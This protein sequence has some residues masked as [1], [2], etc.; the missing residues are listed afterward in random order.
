[1]EA[2]GT[3]VR[4]NGNLRIHAAS[5]ECLCLHPSPSHVHCL[6]AADC[7]GGYCVKKPRADIAARLDVV[8]VRRCRTNSD[9]HGFGSPRQK[10]VAPLNAF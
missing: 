4:R 9:V 5:P 8:G 7:S 6:C 2:I 10:I 1:M 3:V